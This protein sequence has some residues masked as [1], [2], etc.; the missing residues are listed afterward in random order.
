MRISHCVVMAGSL[1]AGEAAQPW[2]GVVAQTHADASREDAFRRCAGDRSPTPPSHLPE[3]IG[4]ILVCHGYANV[5]A[6]VDGPRVVVTFE[7]TRYR[8]E[9]RGLSEAARLLLPEIG[10]GQELVLVPSS[11]A[12][13]LVAASY[14]PLAPER[15]HLPDDARPRPSPTRVTLDLSH[16]P[17]PIFGARRASSSFGRV[18]LVVHPW[19]EAVFGNY[20][21]PVESRTGVAPEIRVALRPGLSVSAQALVTLQDDLNTGESRVRP[22][23]VTLNQTVRLPRNVFVSATAG[24]FNP[25]RYGVDVETRAY[26]ANGSVSVGAEVGLTGAASYAETG[27]FR[28]P[29]DERTALVDATWRIARYD[30]LLR[31]TAG[32]FLEDERGVRVDIIRQFGELDVGWFVL[33]SAEGTNGGVV[34]RI[35]LLPA[36]RAAAAPLRLHM[37]DAFRWQY[38]YRGLVPGGRRYDTGN[39]LEDVGRRLNPNQVSGSISSLIQSNSPVFVRELGSGCHVILNT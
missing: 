30:V 35:P 11:R 16:L 6:V 18:D 2:P 27:W 4:Q 1:L 19:F 12:I 14:A 20:D 32:M 15:R 31:T 38:R 28:T 26:L 33:A 29:T 9:R 34:L 8:D 36:K 37:A 13:P 22:G 7:N 39:S 25:N 23:L 17:P 24:T 10:D 21:N 5:A 3:R